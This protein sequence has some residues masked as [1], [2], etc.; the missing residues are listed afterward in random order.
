MTCKPNGAYL[1]HSNR[2]TAIQRIRYPMIHIRAEGGAM[3][4]V[5]ES[6]PNITDA[7]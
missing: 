3:R 4:S 5:V 6:V 1:E 7:L 2:C